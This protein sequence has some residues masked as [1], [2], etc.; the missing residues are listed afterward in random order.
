[1]T[2]RDF[3]NEFEERAGLSDAATL[4][5]KDCADCEKLHREQSQVWQIIE[6][7]PEVAAPTDFNQRFRARVA[8]AKASDFRPAW[9]KSLRYLGP[10]FAAVLVLTLVFASQNFFVSTSQPEELAVI[11]KDEK[12]TDSINNDAK[13][14]TIDANVISANYNASA[15]ETNLT[16][17]IEQTPA[18]TSIAESRNT[19][20]SEITSQTNEDFIGVRDFGVNAASPPALPNGFPQMENKTAPNP[21]EMSSSNGQNIDSLLSFIGAET[22]FENGK[23]RVNSVQ[24]NSLAARVGLK[25]GDLIEKIDG[26]PVS[27]LEQITTIRTMTVLRGNKAISLT[28]RGQ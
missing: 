2:C 9:W 10:V 13:A 21:T 16:P 25:T 14:D 18:P 11:T 15:N 6:S 20:K 8:T 19:N 24:A 12:P 3:Q 22:A 4:H 1:M 23:R 7:L 28:F 17:K 27:G 5:F 26:K